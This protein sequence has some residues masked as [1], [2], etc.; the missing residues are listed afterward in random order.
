VGKVAVAQPPPSAPT[1]RQ[2][3][4]TRQVVLNHDGAGPVPVVRVAPKVRTYIALDAPIDPDSVKLEGEGTRVRLVARTDTLIAVEGLTELDKG[5]AV[6][7]ATYADGKAPQVLTLALVSDPSQVDNEVQVIRRPESVEAMKAELAATRARCEAQSAELAALKARCEASG[8]DGLALSGVLNPSLKT[9][10]LESPKWS[11]GLAV[12]DAWANKTDGWMVA[13]ALVTNEGPQPWVP[14]KARLTS[15]EP[16]GG[17]RVLP[18][19]MKG[20][21]LAP[22]ETGLVAM[23]IEEPPPSAFRL[24]VQDAEGRPAFIL[25]TEKSPEAQKPHG[26]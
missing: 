16:G 7:V 4:H 25:T 22:G 17:V 20:A 15:T 14:G 19:R 24:E 11:P 21:Q 9:L 3:I 13:G 2:V 5:G 26:K 6:L 8:M 10:K 18:V 23:G 12:L 1:A